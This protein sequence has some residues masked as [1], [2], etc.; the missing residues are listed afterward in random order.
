[1]ALWDQ[2]KTMLSIQPVYESVKPLQTRTIEDMD[3]GSSTLEDLLL[4]VQG[5]TARPWR[6]ASI[7][8]AL[9]VPS[10][11]GAVN[12]IANITGSLSMRALRN[13]IELPPSD[14]PRLVV[15][16]DPFNIPREFYRP[17]AYNLASRGETWWWVAARDGDEMPISIINVSPHEVTVEEDPDDLRYPIIRWRGVRM[18]NEDFRQ[19]VWAREPGSL[20]GHG[21]LQMCGAAISVAV[22]SQEWAANF[23]AG[24]GTPPL[25]IKTA[26]ELG[27]NPDFPDAATEAAALRAQWMDQ[28]VN[29]P[30]VIDPGI[31]A[32]IFP[33]ANNQGAQMLQARA[34]QNIDVA[35]MFNMDA[36]LLNA[37][38]AGTSLTYQNVGTKFEE[39]LR[40][41]L[42]SNVLEPIEQTMSDFLPRSITA[43]FNTAALTLADVTTRYNAY[44]VGIDK[45][46]ITPEEARRFEGFAPGDVENAA[47]P[48][49]PPQA[50]PSSLPIQMRSESSEIRC[51]GR[52]ML[53][54][55]LAPC[56]K[57]LGPSFVGMCPRCKKVH[58]PEAA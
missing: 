18:K 4:R 31:D 47:V 23:Y 2:I 20:R 52:R 38:V 55:I 7:R 34:H 29:T 58:K 9:G 41:C 35:T 13:E 6:P 51:N 22:E 56:N 46:I 8:E 54:G 10:I 19:L 37:A 57:L 36:E 42:R 32:M 14:R 21:P 27:E 43:R 5:T 16:P 49:S 39:F 1:M 11:F 53:R 40:M 12:L 17:T 50:I 30:R 44:G 25:I 15:R 45:G 26:S 24:G 28:D 3:P 33:P 48:Y